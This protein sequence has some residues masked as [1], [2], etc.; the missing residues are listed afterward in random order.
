VPPFGK[1]A[2]PC[3]PS[4]V[5]KVGPAGLASIQNISGLSQ[6]LA[7]RSV[8]GRACEDLCVLFA[9]NATPRRST[10]SERV[11]GERRDRASDVVGVMLYS[12]L[13]VLV[14]LL[15]VCVPA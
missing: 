2:A 15:C 5:L 10:M 11:V 7:G 8:V 4:V 9:R 12:I 3:A 6:G 14:V 1:A 13:A